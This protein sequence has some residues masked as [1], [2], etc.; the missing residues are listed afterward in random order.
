MIEVF[1][2]SLLYWAS[3]LVAFFWLNQRLAGLMENVSNLESIEEG[4]QERR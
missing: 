4:K 2:V 1:L 3:L